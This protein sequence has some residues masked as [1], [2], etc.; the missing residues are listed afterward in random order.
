MIQ[1]NLLE[2]YANVTF[3]V[4]VVPLAFKL[5]QDGLR[6][7]LSIIKQNKRDF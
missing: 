2:N 4:S 5:V 6:S 1:K 7:T 3:T